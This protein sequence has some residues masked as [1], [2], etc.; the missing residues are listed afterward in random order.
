MNFKLILLKLYFIRG[1]MK[2]IMTSQQIDLSHGA[3]VIVKLNWWCI[4]YTD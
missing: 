1:S 2:L 3:A 4:T